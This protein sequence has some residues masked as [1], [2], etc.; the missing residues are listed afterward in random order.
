MERLLCFLAVVLP[1]AVYP[2]VSMITPELTSFWGLVEVDVANWYRMLLVGGVGVLSLFFIRRAEVGLLLYLG[3]LALSSLFSHYKGVIFY[4]TPEHHEGLIALLGYVSIYLMASKV[5]VTKAIEKCFGFVVY[6]SFVVCILQ[7][8]Y[9]GYLNFPLLKIFLPKGEYIAARWPLYGLQAN[10]TYLGLFCAMFLPYAFL[11]KKWLQ[12]ALLVTMLI[13][14]QSKA[15]LF[16][17]VVTIGFI[18]RRHLL[19]AGLILFMWVALFYTGNAHIPLRDS[20]FTGRI[21]MWR[22]ILPQLKKDILIGD[23]PATYPLFIRQPVEDEPYFGRVVIDRPHNMYINIWQNTGFLSLL[24]LG[25]ITILAFEKSRDKALKLG[26]LG[27]LI[28]GIFTDSV[29]CVTPYFLIFLGGMNY[30]Y[31]EA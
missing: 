9:K 6:S 25:V 11:K 27:F 18:H 22:S 10:S 29:L 1:F 3:L 28:T 21:Y 12:V 26:A 14:A 19:T 20:D 2:C 15:A 7:V 31:T 24:I 8:V 13:G 5:G 16:S 17:V 4:G 23:G 30:E